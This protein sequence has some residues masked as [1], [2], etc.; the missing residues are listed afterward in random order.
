MLN[1]SMLPGRAGNS[2]V[3]HSLVI[4]RDISWAVGRRGGRHRLA[5]F[6]Q[7]TKNAERY[8]TF[9]QVLAGCRFLDVYRGGISGLAR[10]RSTCSATSDSWPRFRRDAGG[11]S[12]PSD[13]SAS[14]DGPSL[15]FG[16]GELDFAVAPGV[17]F[18]VSGSEHSSARRAGCDIA[19]VDTI[20]RRAL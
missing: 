12:S 4:I 2:G 15:D 3:I 14:G 9:E 18:A 5:K 20:Y 8:F 17:S 10:T 19:G 16:P 7:G 1:F 13:V 6:T 11:R